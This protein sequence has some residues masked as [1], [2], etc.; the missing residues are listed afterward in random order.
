MKRPLEFAQ[1]STRL[2][3]DD[4]SAMLS[5]SAWRLHTAGLIKAAVHSPHEG[6]L[7][8]SN[9]VLVNRW[10]CLGGGSEAV[11][12]AIAELVA[13]G[14]WIAGTD[15]THQIRHWEKTYAGING[16]R[17]GGEKGAHLRHHVKAAKFDSSCRFCA[18]EAAE[19]TAGQLPAP[20]VVVELEPPAEATAEAPTADPETELRAI[21]DEFTAESAEPSVYASALETL[22]ELAAD[23]SLAQS[24]PRAQQI[25][26][27][28][29]AAA[30]GIPVEGRSIGRITALGKQY[31]PAVAIQALSEAATR[32]GG[33]PVNYAAA[34]LKR[35]AAEVA[36]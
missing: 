24:L 31:G 20:P 9:P 5:D 7:W 32:A 22:G 30:Y 10:A 15:G 25:V 13:I 35:Q 16:Q 1:L 27:L 8:T 6:L 21:L 33:D 23:G 11:A 19:L 18:A 29:A 12:P 26:L 36:A 4:E 14:W 28:H 34:V 2:L 3:T 17:E